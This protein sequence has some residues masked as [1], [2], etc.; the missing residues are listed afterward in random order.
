[1]HA[2]KA[3]QPLEA[4]RQLAR[5]RL[6]QGSTRKEIREELEQLRVRLQAEDREADEDVVLDALDLVTGWCSPHMTI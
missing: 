6:S 5:D 3:P 4:M 1:M 2:L